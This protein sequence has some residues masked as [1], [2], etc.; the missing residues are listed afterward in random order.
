MEFSQPVVEALFSALCVFDRPALALTC[1][2]FYDV[3]KRNRFYLTTQQRQTLMRLSS[4]SA[5]NW[6]WTFSPSF[7]LGGK[8]TIGSRFVAVMQANAWAKAGYA[9][10]LCVGRSI[11]ETYHIMGGSQFTDSPRLALEQGKVWLVRERTIAEFAHRTHAFQRAVF[12]KCRFYIDADGK[13]D[14]SF[15][16]ASKTGDFVGVRVI[17]GHVFDAEMARAPHRSLRFWVPPNCI[18]CPSHSDPELS[19][20]AQILAHAQ[21]KPKA[22]IVLADKRM[23]YTWFNCHTAGVTVLRPYHTATARR[24]ILRRFSR[25][26]TGTLVITQRI[27]SRSPPIACSDIYILDNYQGTCTKTRRS[28]VSHKSLR[29][30]VSKVWGPT[31]YFPTLTMYILANKPSELAFYYSLMANISVGTLE[32]DQ[33]L[34]DVYATLQH[35]YPQARIRMRLV[36]DYV[37]L[38]DR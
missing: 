15:P 25:S 4:L 31:N 7:C 29:S 12:D 21:Q 32:E 37:E 6:T 34:A 23:A 22:V 9:T 5:S 1:H 35:H 33:S 19:S 18:A 17:A 24:E 8:P 27:L 10:L 38:L 28:S 14:P 20:Y 16:F 11:Y 30:I 13:L 2:W 36:D 3:Y 26:T